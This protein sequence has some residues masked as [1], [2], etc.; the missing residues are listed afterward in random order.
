MHGGGWAVE[1]VSEENLESAFVGCSRP[2]VTKN[3][4]GVPDPLLPKVVHCFLVPSER[5][6]EVFFFCTVLF[7]CTVAADDCYSSALPRDYR[8]HTRL[9]TKHL[10]SCD[11]LI[12]P[13]RR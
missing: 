8:S 12:H 2:R 4:G 9:L 3:Y 6:Q 7:F 5:I 11:A 13:G 10:A 1:A